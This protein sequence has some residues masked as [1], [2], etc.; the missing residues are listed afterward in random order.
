[1]AREEVESS[2]NIKAVGHKAKKLPPKRRKRTV[3]RRTADLGDYV[4]V[5][6][7]E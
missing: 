7:R 3:Q 6:Q 5:C 4:W 2:P 1:M